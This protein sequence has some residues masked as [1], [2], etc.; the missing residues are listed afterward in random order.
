MHCLIGGAG[1]DFIFGGLQADRILG[2][3]GNDTI[4]ANGGDDFIDSGA[5]L[6]SVWLGAGAATVVLA[7][8]EGYDTING[9]Q[10]GATK[11]KVSSLENLHFADSVQGAQIF[12]NHDL[13]A[14]VSW[15]QASTI[16]SNVSGIF[17]V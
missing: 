13:L 17:V 5:G 7:A 10:L 2:G 9:F 15:Q 8:G 3:T 1:D 12:Q 11:F 4:Y 6:D 16:S 14:V